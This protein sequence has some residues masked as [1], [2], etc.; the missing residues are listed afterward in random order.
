ME[1]I[2][3]RDSY[4]TGV[5]QLDEQ[6]KQLIA[7][8]NKLYGVIRRKEGNE[9]LHAVFDDLAAYAAT[10]LE[11]EEKLLEG[12]AY[13]DLDEHRRQHAEYVAQVDELRQRLET[14]D[15]Q[16]VIE[17]YSYLRQW[18]LNHIVVEDKAYGPFLNEKGIT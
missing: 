14:A 7:I 11:D 18:W 10:H 15:Q 17:I 6:H 5:S 2:P 3:W 13:P 1:A 8:I 16:L 12:Y 9:A 4:E